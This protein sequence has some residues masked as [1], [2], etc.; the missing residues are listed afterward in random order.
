M[1]Q[2]PVRAS[3]VRSACS[4]AQMIR[5]IFVA[6]VFAVFLAWT[7]RDVPATAAPAAHIFAAR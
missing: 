4:T 6:A 1:S 3:K 2:S 5:A 7:L